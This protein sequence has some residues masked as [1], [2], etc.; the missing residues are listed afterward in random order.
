MYDRL[1]GFRDFYPGEMSARRE[2]VD[3]VETA[4]ARY[5]FR[6]IG[7]PHLER[8]QMYVDKSGE[9]IVEELYAFEDKG[10]REVTLTPELTP[11][12]ARMVVAKQQALSKP[13]KWV[14]TR[15]FW[16]YEQVQQ[17]RFREFYQTNADIFG[18]SEPE[19]DA[20]ILAFC[21]DALTDLGLTADDFEFRVS[22]RDILGGLLR[23]F[24]ADVDVADAVRA[25]DKS[26][27]VE[28][29]EYLGLLSDAGLSYDQAGEFAD[30]IERG[31][32]DEIAEF[33]GDD[34]EAAV[35]NLRNVLAA[36][37]DFGA[38][39]FCEVSLSTARGLDYYTGVVF[40]CFDSTGDV[41]RAT[42]GGGRYDD[43][44]ESFG[45]QPTPAVGVGIGGATLQLLCQ[46]AGVWPE[47]ELATDYYLLTVGDT[48]AVASDIARDLRTA[49][50]V[51][52]VDVSG[53][54]FGAQMSYA[55]SVN[56]DTVVIVGERDLE[57]GEVTVK[58]MASGDQTTV[59]VDD[60]P[61]DRDAPTYEDYE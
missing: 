43:L 56:A 39:E 6:E 22:H 17:G 54:S 49:G 33:G 26:E 40:E 11:T 42:F 36:A 14:S 44:I 3:T 5:G 46:R 48:R 4:A 2:V 53:R 16:R 9:E 52:E 10:G 12:V 23:S 58:D 47:E 60:F 25:V 15:P 18:S 59:P 13:I 30:L 61:G 37:D 24:D 20:E 45:G 28:R 35:E 55:D 41:S 38:G 51:V 34:V 8:T 32:L 57:N 50:N 19:A 7:T 27:K 29:E 21:A 31:D 1:K